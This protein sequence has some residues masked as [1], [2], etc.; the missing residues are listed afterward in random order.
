[1]PGVRT[2][3]RYEAPV[4]ARLPFALPEREGLQPLERYAY[5]LRDAAG[6]DSVPAGY[7]EASRGCLHTCAHCPITPV[8]GGRF[9]VVPRAIVLED[10]RRQVAMGARHITFG[11]PDFFNGPGHSMAI[12]RGAARGVPGADLRRDDQG[13][14]YSGAAGADP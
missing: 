3:A 7:V 4:L 2:R 14:A 5:L 11:D 1:M 10:V 6:E 13:G 9:F 12:L 8:Y